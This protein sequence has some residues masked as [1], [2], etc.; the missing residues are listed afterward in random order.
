MEIVYNQM[1]RAFLR[2]HY[3]GSGSESDPVPNFKAG[4]RLRI[5]FL[6][7]KHNKTFFRGKQVFSHIFKLYEYQYRVPYLTIC[8]FAWSESGSAFNGVLDT[9]P[10]PEGGKSSY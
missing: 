4:I 3:C 2:E 1:A 10:D 8:F 7:N 9:N 5:L 6:R